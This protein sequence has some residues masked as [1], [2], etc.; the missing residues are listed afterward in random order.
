ML[1]LPPQ[2]RLFVATQPVD[3]RTGLD[4]LAAV[5]RH[6]LGDHPLAGAVDVFRHR[7]A[8]ALNLLLSD[9]QGSWM[10]MQRLSQGRFAWWPTSPDARVPLS[11]RERRMVLWHG[12]PE[13]A[14]MARDGRRV[15][16][17]EARLRASAQGSHAAGSATTSPRCSGSATRSST[18]LPPA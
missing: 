14:Q 16:S 3:C 7:S 6:A 10:L 2:S 5:C 18:A 15:A 4:G 1:Q 13:R 17:G 8:T 9:G 11:A 12:N